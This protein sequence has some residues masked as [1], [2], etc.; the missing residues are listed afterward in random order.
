MRT[1]ISRPETGNPHNAVKRQVVREGFSPNAGAFWI[2]AP[3]PRQ[4]PPR[5]KAPMPR[6]VSHKPS[7]IWEW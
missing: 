3:A 6:P 5:A 4:Q 7:F 1:K 2:T